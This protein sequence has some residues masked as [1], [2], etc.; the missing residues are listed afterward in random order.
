MMRTKKAATGV[1]LGAVVAVAAA[2]CGGGGGSTST[3]TAQSTGAAAKGG[4]LYMLNL[5]PT[6]H[7][8]P[9]RIYV[10]A[11]I[12]FASRVFERTLTTFPPGATKEEQSKLTPDLATDTGTMS[13]G[14][15]M[16]KFTIRDDAKWQDGKPVTCADVKYGISRTFATDVITGGPNYAISY[17]D[18]PGKPDGSSEYAGPYK[19]TGQALYDKAVS[20]AGNVLT[21]KMK[22]PFTD[23]NQ[24][25]T[26]PAFGP[27]RQDKDQGAK[28]NYEVFS[29]GPYMLQGAWTSNKGG[30]FVRNPSWTEASDPIRKAYPDSIVYQEGI[31]TETVVQRIMA[32]SGNDKF[33]V[34]Q[35]TAPPALQAQIQSNPQVKA[36]STNPSAPYVDYLVPNFKSKVMANDKARMAFAMATDKDAYITAQGGPT[37][38]DPTNAMINKALAGYK[39]FDTT[40]VPSAGDPAKA[41]A[42]LQ[43]SGLTLPVP[44]TVA[45]RKRPTQDKALS[46]MAEA[47][48]KAGFKVTLNGIAQNYYP[49]VQNPSQSAKFDVMWA[50]W[51]ADWP[52]GSTVIPPLFDSR[53]NLSADSTGQDYG[54]FK[55]DA[56]N[57]QMDAALEIPDAAA[58]EKAWGDIDEAIQKKVGSVPLDNQKFMFVHGSGVKNY[59][60]NAILGGYVELATISVK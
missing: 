56:I 18:I 12:Q 35:G 28:S 23:F 25:V 19:K 39:Q 20:C 10:G 51:G 8:D 52:S 49:T 24:A 31:E 41:K 16:W 40:G 53:P 13:D 21:V 9:Q 50:G 54:S 1:A 59:T 3:S 27:Y 47:W 42:L 30:T 11:D 48:N 14:G 32:D 5:G 22:K 15:K 17:F 46:A 45:Y 58:R 6:D 38:A 2:A 43:Q 60:D 33:A 29:N 36:R 26:F 4:T 55:D 7:W 34:T 57:K 44:I 37:A